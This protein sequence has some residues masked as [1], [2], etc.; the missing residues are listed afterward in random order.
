MS[1]VH[2]YQGANCIYTYGTN[3]KHLKPEGSER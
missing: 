2:I 1:T 3:L